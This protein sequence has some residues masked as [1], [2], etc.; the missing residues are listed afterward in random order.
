MAT[1]K[2]QAKGKTLKPGRS[3]EKKQPLT[4]TSRFDPYKGYRF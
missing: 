2:K 4:N 1:K 3:L